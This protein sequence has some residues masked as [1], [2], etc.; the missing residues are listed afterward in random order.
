MKQERWELVITPKIESDHINSDVL[1]Q[2][3]RKL[4]GILLDKVK[5]YHAEFLAT[6]D[7]P[8]MIPKA[9][10]KRWHPEFNIEMVPD[11]E[12]AE[13]PKPPVEEKFTSGQDVL[14]KARQMFN[15]NTRMEQALLKLH[16]AKSKGQARPVEETK[17][18]PTSV[19]K[20]R[21]V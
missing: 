16:E 9:D 8:I 18:T 17:A 14:E 13:L 4:F 7:P 21:L 11:V 12:S 15:C 20:G 6:L 2:R 1:L 5:T 10:I 19:L 3:R